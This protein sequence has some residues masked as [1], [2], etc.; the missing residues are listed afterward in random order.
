[1]GGPVLRCSSA[2]TQGAMPVEGVGDQ[3]NVGGRDP[4]A[5]EEGDP[6]RAEPDPA[7]G[8]ARA[9][10]QHCGAREHDDTRD[11]VVDDL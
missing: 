5:G 11:D 9:G 2:V 3:R 8:R 1:M 6:A 7:A 10:G 4:Q